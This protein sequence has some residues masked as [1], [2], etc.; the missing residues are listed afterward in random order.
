MGER[1]RYRIDTGAG[2]D[3]VDVMSTDRN[4]T[5]EGGDGN[6]TIRFSEDPTR[7]LVPAVVDGGAGNDLILGGPLGD[8]LTGGPGDDQVFGHAGDDRLLWTSGDGSDLLEGG[9]GYDTVVIQGD[10]TGESFDVAPVAGSRLI[11]QVASS[12]LDIGTV[13]ATGLFGGGGANSFH[14][15]PTATTTILVHGQ[16]S[17]GGSGDR[18]V[19]DT[20]NTVS[21]QL[22]LSSPTAGTWTFGGLQPI[23]FDGIAFFNRLGLFAVSSGSSQI[24]TVDIRNPDG[25]V[26]L[27][28]TPASRR[29]PGGFRTA[30]GDVNGDGTLDLITYAAAGGA[31]PV[32]VFDGN[33]ARSSVVPCIP[34]GKA[35]AGR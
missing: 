35:S 25:T 7:V 31:H 34:S 19:V 9:T 12:V 30:M 32:L 14:V 22:T 4:L 21:P 1:P 16:A 33:T 15:T 23:T 6:D 13:E 27:V 28:V 18:L 24:A 11:A 17:P 3:T 29:T 2:D 5:I 8:T 20:Q 10:A 26:R